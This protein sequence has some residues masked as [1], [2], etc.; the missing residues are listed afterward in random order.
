MV[1][2]VARPGA[3]GRPTRGLILLSNMPEVHT[4]LVLRRAILAMKH[5]NIGFA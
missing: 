3:V 2:S 5:C 4:A 1:L